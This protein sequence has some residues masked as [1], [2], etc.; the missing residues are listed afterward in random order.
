MDPTPVTVNR[1]SWPDLC[2]ALLIFRA[3]P[4]ALNLT[5]LVLALL[6]AVSVPLGWIV[7]EK[8]FL[9]D[10]SLADDPELRIVKEINRSPFKAVYPAWQQGDSLVS[11][12]GHQLRGME[13]VFKSIVTP[14][15]DLFSIKPGLGRFFYFLAGS[16]WMLLVWSFF[17]C[18]ICRCALMRYTR[19]DP[20][21]LDEAFNY[22]IDKFL[23][24]FAGVAIPL[25]AVFLLAIPVAVIGLLMT[26]DFGA[27]IGGLLWFVVLALALAMA[28]ILFGLYFAW[29]LIVTAIGCEGQDSFDGIS[30]AFAYV[31]QRPVHYVTYVLI[32]VVFSGICWVAMIAL[33]EGTLLAAWWASSWG[34]NVVEYRTDDLSG[35]FAMPPSRVD[36]DAAMTGLSTANPPVTVDDES[37]DSGSLRAGRWLIRFWNGVARTLGAAFLYGL[38]W[39][40]ASAVYLLLRKDLDGTEMDEIQVVDERRTWE[41]PPLRETESGVPAVDREESGL[42]PANGDGDD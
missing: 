12:L 42:P 41:L 6:G 4:A 9:S 28:V 32:G 14:V 13:L 18:A 31:F 24:C 21:G 25:L 19:D 23:S 30:R 10:A 27:L 2:P 16:L 17:G 37:N 39:C 8:V 22:A 11:V 5:V 35:E 7:A 29:P 1:F 36:D 38:F 33:V 34:S 26:T 40:I 3:L 15:G 20:P